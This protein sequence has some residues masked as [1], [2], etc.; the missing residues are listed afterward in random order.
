LSEPVNEVR[1]QIF[2]FAVVQGVHV[3]AGDARTKSNS[4]V[5]V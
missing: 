5:I 4:G 3:A 1:V 2:F